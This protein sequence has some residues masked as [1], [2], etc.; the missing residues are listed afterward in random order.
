M[1]LYCYLRFIGFVCFLTV[2][3]S[4]GW[5]QPVPIFNLSSNSMHLI[6][7][8]INIRPIVYSM[9]CLKSC[10]LDPTYNKTRPAVIKLFF[11]LL[12]ILLC[13]ALTFISMINK[14]SESLKAKYVCIFGILVNLFSIII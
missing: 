10:Y 2:H 12:V 6:L 8:A 4:Q 9:C 3:K 1:L 13:S 7:T 11:M 14:T 5:L